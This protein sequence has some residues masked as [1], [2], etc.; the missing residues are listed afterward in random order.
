MEWGEPPVFPSITLP[1]PLQLPAPVLEV[2]R[3]EIPSYKPLVVPPSDLRPPPGVKSNPAKEQSKST[4]PKPPAIPI[5]P[6]P[7][8]PEVQTFDVP[9]T[10]VTLPVPSGEVLVTAATTAFVSVAATLTATSLFKHLVSLF[11]PVFKQ[12]WNKITKKT[13]SSN[14]LS[15][16]GPP[17]S[18][19][20]H[21]QDG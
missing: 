10:D 2:P 9:G 15:L 16:S 3:A 17:D 14:S 8:I 6:P 21:T 19:P 18:S 12:A 13:D 11:K 20:H 4:T 1:E 7:K 5:P